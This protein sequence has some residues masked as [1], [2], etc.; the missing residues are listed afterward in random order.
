M[1][2]ELLAC[3][4]LQ[5]VVG[6]VQYFMGLPEI[7]IGLHM[8]G[9]AL[10]WICVLRVSLSLRERGPLLEEDPDEAAA[11]EPGAPEPQSAPALSR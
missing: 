6:Y 3:L 9:S 10:V 7:V 11:D 1:V 2:L 8:L 4:A 5:G